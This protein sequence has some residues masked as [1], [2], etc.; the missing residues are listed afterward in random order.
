[1]VKDDRLVE[2]LGRASAARDE[3]LE[4]DEAAI[5][6]TETTRL[7]HLQRLTRLSYLDPTLIRSVLQGTHPK[8]LSARCLLRMGKLPIRFADQREGLGFSNS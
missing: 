2:L 3:L 4:M 6:L 7:R 5:Q 1:M 8:S